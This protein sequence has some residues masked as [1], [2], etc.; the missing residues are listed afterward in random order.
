MNCMEKKKLVVLSGAGISAESGVP[1]YRGDEGI[2]NNLSLREL[3]SLRGWKQK[4]ETVID[5]YNNRR[6]ALADV[7]PNKAHLM[8][9]KMERDFDVVILTQ[10]VDDLHERA[11]SSHIVHLHGELTCV[12]PEDTYNVED[13]FSEEYVLRVGY[14][15]VKLGDTGGKNHTQLRPHVVFFGEPVV[16]MPDAIREAKSADILLIIG[17]SLQVYPAAD[18]INMAGPDCD[19]YIIDP[20]DLTFYTSRPPCH[21][22]EKATVGIEA[23]ARMIGFKE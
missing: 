15:P 2:W 3:A 7:R 1:V 12:R 17:T 14:N 18:L 19:V 20:N 6:A 21:I 11:G 9:A 22:K 16:K 8:L 5:F 10:N 4:T 23:F 13:G